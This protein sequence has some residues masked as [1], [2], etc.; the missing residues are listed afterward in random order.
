[1]NILLNQS[2][3]KPEIVWQNFADILEDDLL[4]K[5]LTNIYEIDNGYL[6]ELSAPG[7]AKEDFKI[8][9]DKTLLTIEYNHRAEVN[10][11]ANKKSIKVEFKNHSFKKNFYL[12]ED[13]QTEHIKAKYDNGILT[14]SLPKK[15]SS[16]LAAMNIQVQ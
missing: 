5:P 6:I 8:A 7:C 13:I 14:I 11:Q 9:M 4:K 12:D 16:A 2:F 10:E 3:K 15:E 1:M